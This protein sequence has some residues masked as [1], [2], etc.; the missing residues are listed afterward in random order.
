MGFS[1]PPKTDLISKCGEFVRRTKRIDCEEALV[2]CISAQA[3][4]ILFENGFA[5][6]A[7][8]HEVNQSFIRSIKGIGQH[9]LLQLRE[10]FKQRG[11]DWK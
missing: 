11:Y 3:T 2:D 10:S 9:T 4:S 6:L 5:T 1:I 7:D 8:I